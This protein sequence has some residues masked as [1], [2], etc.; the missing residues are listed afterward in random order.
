MREV[1]V[2]FIARKLTG[3]GVRDLGAG[4]QLS[5]LLLRWCSPAWE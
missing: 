3:A 5:V 2:D 1:S 4:Q